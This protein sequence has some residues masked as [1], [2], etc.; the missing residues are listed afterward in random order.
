MLLALVLSTGIATRT[1]DAQVGDLTQISAAKSIRAADLS[2]SF[3]AYRM[4][5]V[6]GGNADPMGGM[7][8]MG[9]YFPMLML[10]AAMS[11]S[12]TTSSGNT[13]FGLVMMLNG[14]F[15]SDF[16]TL[17]L[18]NETFISG[19]TVT[20]DLASMMGSSQPPADVE[21]VLILQPT[22]IKASAITAIMPQPEMTASRYR[23]ILV[24][25]QKS[26]QQ[27]IDRPATG[28]TDMAAPEGFAAAD[29]AAP[30]SAQTMG[31]NNAKQ[32]ALGMIMYITDYD[33]V[34]PKV[35]ST[36]EVQKLIWPYLKNDEVFKTN[37]SRGSTFRFNMRL[38]GKSM[39][40]IEIPSETPLFFESNS[41]SDGRRIVAY[42]DGHVKFVS[43]QEFQAM[44]RRFQIKL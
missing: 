29:V 6:G 42:V 1:T 20:L 17:Q 31:L 23:Q 43:E 7:G 22:F 5:Y 26:F 24:E 44:V 18:G 9:L 15:F 25:L 34:Y 27:G 28:I 8:M 37:N 2:D 35:N 16:K 19:Y 11:G 14:L 10:G 4:S 33:D 41:W 39:D 12:S 21:S 32:L 30:A 13:G 38:S 36:G 40:S 3:H